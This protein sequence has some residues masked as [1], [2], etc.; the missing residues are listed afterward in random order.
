MAEKA[1]KSNAL[2]IECAATTFNFQ[3]F[4]KRS[5][6]KGELTAHSSN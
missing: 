6:S 3:L 2:K 5:N 1:N 4:N